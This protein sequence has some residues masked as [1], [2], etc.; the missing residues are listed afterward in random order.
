[1]GMQI[2]PY[3]DRAV[4]VSLDEAAATQTVAGRL[5]IKLPDALVRVGMTSV[6]V[7]I[8]E[9]S[10]EL[11]S[12]VATVLLDDVSE[13]QAR[14]VSI[15]RTVEIP[16]EYNGEDLDTLASYLG[17]SKETLV[18]AHSQTVWRVA[19]IGFA[20]G[21]PYL[22]P[23]EASETSRLFDDVP[24]LPSPRRKVPTGS[25]AVAAGMSTIYPS[26]MPGGWMLLG[27]S[28][29][30]LFDPA[31]DP[32]SLLLPGDLVQFTPVTRSA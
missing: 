31:V 18:Q 30:T 14:P 5:S 22:V 10:T 8:P 15:G 24:R 28:P 9:P 19:I 25:V 13:L 21:H 16:V 2:H 32:P 7:E 29:V 20:P 4:L 12:R 23:A 1:M 17:C 26:A 6:L 3:G 27:I 11:Q